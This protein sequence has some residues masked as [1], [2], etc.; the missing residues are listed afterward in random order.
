MTRAGLSDALKTA[1]ALHQQGRL[2]EAEVLYRAVIKDDPN[3]FDA[4][5]LLGVIASQR[6]DYAA[7]ALLF[8][9]AVTLNPKSALAHASAGNALAALHRHAEA[10]ESFERSLALE[11]DHPE[12]L[13]NV[14][15]ALFELGRFAEALACYN[16]SLMHRAGSAEVL[17]N[18]GNAL[19][20]LGRPTQAL[21]DY[22]RALAV[23]AAYPQVLNKR[24]AALRELKR[25]DEA[26]ASYDRALAIKADY[27]EALNDRGNALL[28]LGRGEE[29]LASYERALT[30]RPEFAEALYNKGTAL[31][32]L[33]RHGEAAREF[34][35]LLS[36]RPDFA[37]A[38]GELL[39]AQLHC[40]EWTDR[41]RLTQQV[42]KDVEAG[43]RAATPFAFLSIS[44]SPREQLQ[45]A[46]I[47]CKDKLSA[48][49]RPLWTGERYRHDKIRVAYISA[50]FHD[51]ATAYL[52]AELFE[53]H[54]R[55]RDEMRTRLEKA[56]T[57][58]VDVRG[59]SDHDIAV[60]L[61]EREIDIAVDLKGHTQHSRPRIFAARPAP[62]QVNYLGYPGTTGA[63]FMDYIIADRITIPDQQ[64][65]FYTEKVVH[66][67]D[68]YQPTDSTRRIGEWTPT[69]SEV[70]LPES[71]FVFSSFVAHYKI[72]PAIF[73][74]WM[75]LLTEIEGSV[76]WL[77]AGNEHAVGNLRRSAQ[78]RGIAPER[79]V[80]AP[81]MKL[82][83]HLARQSLADLFL[84]TLPINAHTTGS[85]ALWAGVPLLTC[86]GAGFA[87]RVAGSLL[88]AVGLPELITETPDAYEALALE[89]ARN[90]G[91]LAATRAKLAR[92]RKTH[93]LFDTERLR[94]HIESAFRTMFLRCQRGEQ[95]VG[96]DVAACGQRDSTDP[97]SPSDPADML[98]PGRLNELAAL[99]KAGRLVELENKSREMLVKYPTSGVIWQ[100]LGISLA[101]Q[102]KD[103][104]EAAQRAADFLPQDAG[105]L[106][107]LG[108][109]LGRVGRLDEAAR[110]YQQALILQ[111]QSAEAHQNLGNV[112][113]DLGQSAS[114]AASCR[115]ALEL[116]PDYAEAHETLGNALLDLGR[117]ADAAASYRRALDIAPQ[118]AETHNNLGCALRALGK[119][120]EALASFGRAIEIE[121]NFADAHCNRGIALRLKG[122]T[123]EAQAACRKALEIDPQSTA[124][125]MV[126][127]EALADKG[128]FSDAEN[129]FK[130]I[131]S[132]EPQSPQAW[133]GIARS[134]KMTSN[135]S[136]WLTQAQRIA[137]GP[138]AYRQEIPLR[139]AIGKY[140]DDVRD[141]E[142]AHQ[143]FQ[144]AHELAKRHGEKHDRPGLTRV[145]DEI[146]R[147]CDR[148]WLRRMRAG[149]NPSTRPVFIVGMLRSGTTL[150]EH[151]LASHPAV[152]G[153]GEL[154]FWSTVS[155]MCSTSAAPDA[156][157]RPTLFGLAGDYLRILENLSGDALRVV[158]KMP[159]NFAFL[160]LIH[161]ALPNARIIHMQRHPLD[162]CLSIYCQHFESAVSYANDLED[163]AHYY[164]EYRR[165]MHHWESVLPEEAVLHVPY[166][167]LVS[168][169][170]AWSRAMLNFIGLPWDPRCL[171]FH[172]T[173]RSIVTASKW[174]V[175]QKITGS[176]VG[177]WRHYEKFLAPL[178]GLTEPSPSAAPAERSNCE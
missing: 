24:G 87:G 4:H 45:C 41:A 77:L 21:A 3:H 122:R 115:S 144:R 48:P 169:P 11:P 28:E 17:F 22:D 15:N 50:D 36:L 130:R 173:H 121:P 33:S 86:L 100:I 177:R 37:Y 170:E 172:Q 31:S 66:V 123:D 99:M 96:F 102:G 98:P 162:N 154:T 43:K 23:R 114:A 68:S 93:P 157:G 9:R 49:S 127:A 14:G 116:R 166:E 111:P 42:R 129:L 165:V 64:H 153:A 58:F 139:Y 88:N 35:R 97:Q 103:A 76:L 142:R 52:T 134:R 145:V 163:L 140:F 89:L 147:S 32:A 73:D 168:D 84:D 148:D 136:D 167:A 16:R 44:E 178:R 20:E 109:A 65:P 78:A 132:I 158:D 141:F 39:H 70:G 85:D 120:D 46:K 176:S 83:R 94:R 149:S 54:D 112:L 160:G 53:L 95:P 63:D 79:L 135:D 150:A 104:L 82:E 159:T 61:R 59:S 1:L 175:R 137:D 118:F 131:I 25:F 29:A 119:L 90:G 81:R 126:L 30:A 133:A 80:F 113:L 2:S 57:H 75:R 91:R 155:T 5:S 51:H 105:A 56:F 40:C 151:I 69:R 60:L 74:C 71:G 92:T 62:V 8:N 108:N 13:N 27:A 138:L 67:P 12:V 10:V 34:S 164:T 174:Q 156:P 106:I 26:L 18:R 171:D 110:K 38:A 6:R 19:L 47:Y 152:F 125:W 128:Q 55:S 146:I 124:A 7:A 161:A 72:V 117:L 101:R 107:N 143:N